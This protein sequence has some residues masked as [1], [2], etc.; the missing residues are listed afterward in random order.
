MI[1][2]IIKNNT[3]IPEYYNELIFNIDRET[4]WLKKIPDNKFSELKEEINKTNDDFLI[5]FYG[6]LTFLDMKFFYS[7]EKLEIKTYKHIKV[8]KKLKKSLENL[9]SIQDD[10]KNKYHLI[11]LYLKTINDKDLSIIK[12]YI[13]SDYNFKS[14][15]ILLDNK[16]EVIKKFKKEIEQY[17]S[18]LSNIDFINDDKFID[19]LESLFNQLKIDTRILIDRKNSIKNHKDNIIR[20][21]KMSEINIDIEVDNLY[22]L[23]YDESFIKCLENLPKVKVDSHFTKIMKIN[24]DNYIQN[25]FDL[26]DIKKYFFLMQQLIEKIDDGFIKSLTSDIENSDLSDLYKEIIIKILSTDVDVMFKIDS[27]SDKFEGIIR[28]NLK[29][30][31]IDTTYVDNGKSEE[32]TLSISKNGL[33]SILISEYPCE[34]KRIILLNNILNDRILFNIRNKSSHSLIDEKFYSENNYKLLLICLREIINILK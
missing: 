5:V 26:I 15:S 32:K 24:K 12:D 1:L 28:E 30:K 25:D 6:C 20:N 8:N 33:L 7:N 4:I 9:I 29:S 19:R 2:T 13:I 11:K 31:N 3:N 17:L 10:N 27:L 21:M 16:K 18:S 22:R 23:N 34:E 14:L